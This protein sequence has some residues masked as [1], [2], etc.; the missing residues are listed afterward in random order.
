MRVYHHVKTCVYTSYVCI[1]Q[2]EQ[3]TVDG[4][5]RF[6]SI[7][8]VSVYHFVYHFPRKISYVVL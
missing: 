4:G 7:L 8:T 2:K 6:S 3:T 1:E 5:L